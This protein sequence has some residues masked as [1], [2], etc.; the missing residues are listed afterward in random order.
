MIRSLVTNFESIEW[1]KTH[2]TMFALQNNSG[3]GKTPHI[4]LDQT[5]DSCPFQFLIQKF[6][7]KTK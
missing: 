4:I 6:W 1:D 5:Q 7:D 3:T 2:Y